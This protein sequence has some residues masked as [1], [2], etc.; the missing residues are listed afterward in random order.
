MARGFYT[1]FGAATTDYMTMGLTRAGSDKRSYSVWLYRN[2]GGGTGFGVIFA[3]L[4]GAGT[5]ENFT[6]GTFF[7]NGFRYERSNNS[8]AAKTLKPSSSTN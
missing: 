8:G 2:S 1:T 4:S 3:K 7:T 6:V 5:S